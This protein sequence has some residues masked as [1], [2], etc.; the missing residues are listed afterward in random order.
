MGGVG[1][2]GGVKIQ[3][4]TQGLIDIVNTKLTV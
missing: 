3:Q 4:L 1:C 2:G